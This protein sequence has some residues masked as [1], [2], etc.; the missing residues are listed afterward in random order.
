[1]KGATTLIPITAAALQPPGQ[2]G[3]ALF[4]LQ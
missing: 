4:N 1:M 2:S 3:V